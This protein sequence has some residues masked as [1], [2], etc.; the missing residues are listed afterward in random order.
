MEKATGKA[1]MNNKFLTYFRLYMHVRHFSRSLP[2]SAPARG[3]KLL[4]H[5]FMLKLSFNVKT[6][7]Y[8]NFN[9]FTNSEMFVRRMQINGKVIWIIVSTPSRFCFQPGSVLK[10][11]SCEIYRVK[12]SRIVCVW[13]F[14][15]ASLSTF[16]FHSFPPELSHKTNSL[17]NLLPEQCLPPLLKNSM[18]AMFVRLM[19]MLLHSRKMYKNSLAFIINVQ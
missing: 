14:E 8:E 18:D 19:W 13:I 1:K 17:E 6:L 15:S 2:S 4:Y 16:F 12:K 5:F 9:S 7:E 3:W 11:K 10:R